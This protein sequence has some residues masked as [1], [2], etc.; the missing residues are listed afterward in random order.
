MKIENAV[1]LLYQRIIVPAMRRVQI[2]IRHSM[3]YCR[4]L[5]TAVD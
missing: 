5:P 1:P 4:A 3:N 2:Y